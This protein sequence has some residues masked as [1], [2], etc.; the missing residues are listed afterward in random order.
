[1]L[2]T[3][4]YIL[5]LV[6]I[7]THGY[8]EEKGTTFVNSAARK[9]M[10]SKGDALARK[11][12]D[13]LTFLGRV[14]AAASSWA[15]VGLCQVEWPAPSGNLCQIES[16]ADTPPPR[17]AGSLLSPAPR[18]LFLG[19]SAPSHPFEMENLSIFLFKNKAGFFLGGGD[20]FFYK[21]VRRN[22]LSRWCVL[23][24]SPNILPAV[25]CSTVA[26]QAH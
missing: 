4:N 20:S 14:A 10:H 24:F 7:F 26:F 6:C 21:F 18:D 8:R 23:G 22:V 11:R 9:A 25:C 2:D 13:I 15:S 17:Q 1:M 3:G 16:S 5:T 12:F 19:S